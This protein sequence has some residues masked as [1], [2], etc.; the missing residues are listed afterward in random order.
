M[1]FPEQTIDCRFAEEGGTAGVDAEEQSEEWCG[2]PANAGQDC[3]AVSRGGETR[4]CGE[5]RAKEQQ[6]SSPNPRTERSPGEGGHGGGRGRSGWDGGVL[7]QTLGREWVA[8][9]LSSTKNI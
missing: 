5:A 6:T 7:F 9:I 8:D 2:V 3:K 4:E 1:F